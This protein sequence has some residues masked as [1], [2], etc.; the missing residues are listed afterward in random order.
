MSLHPET[1]E[2]AHL[3]RVLYGFM[4]KPIGFMGKPMGFLLWQTMV[5]LC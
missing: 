2:S 1:D 4:G 3:M 5:K